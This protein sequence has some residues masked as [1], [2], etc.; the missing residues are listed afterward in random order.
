MLYGILKDNDIKKI[1]KTGEEVF[2]VN[3]LVNKLHLLLAHLSLQ[4]LIG[5]INTVRIEVN[6]DA[7]AAPVGK[8]FQYSTFTA[9]YLHYVDTATKRLGGLYKRQHISACII[10]LLI[11]TYFIV[12]VLFEGQVPANF[13]RC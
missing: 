13:K 10:Y 9:A 2:V 7:V 8:R 4:K 11:E 5:K 3:V 6:A 1:V 12:F